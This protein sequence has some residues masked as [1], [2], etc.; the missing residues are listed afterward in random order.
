MHDDG[1]FGESLNKVN[2]KIDAKKPLMK[3]KKDEEPNNLSWKTKFK[4]I[5]R[6][7]LGR[8]KSLDNDSKDGDECKENKVNDVLMRCR[9]PYDKCSQ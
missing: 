4:S 1:V 3:L 2:K 8:G 5:K 6:S 9:S 7:S